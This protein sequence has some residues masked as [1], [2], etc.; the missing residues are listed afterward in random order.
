[1]AE[2][3]PTPP[4]LGRTPFPPVFWVANLIE[5]LERF[6]YYGIY[7]SFGIYMSS[8]GYSRGDLGVVQAR[9][10]GSPAVRKV[11]RSSSS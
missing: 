7:F 8:L 2:S 3:T 10:S 11:T 9:D 6:A 5:V 4:K 1:M